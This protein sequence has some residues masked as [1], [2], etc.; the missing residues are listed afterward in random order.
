MDYAIQYDALIKL[1]TSW[2]THRNIVLEIGFG[3]G[4]HLLSRAPLEPE[5]SFPGRRGTQTSNRQYL[6]ANPNR[7][8]T[9]HSM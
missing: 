5:T 7:E 9:H 6:E 3:Q 2:N 8:H 4:E 1:P